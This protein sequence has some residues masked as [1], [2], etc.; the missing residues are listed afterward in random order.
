MASKFEE[1]IES[2]DAKIELEELIEDSENMLN[3]LVEFGF[4]DKFSNN[5]FIFDITIDKHTS[6]NNESFDGRQMK[7]AILHQFVMGYYVASCKASEK[8]TKAVHQ[9]QQKIQQLQD[10]CEKKKSLIIVP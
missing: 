2:L 8:H 4:I 3:K 5:G 6:W 10:I 9:Y 7:V 1:A